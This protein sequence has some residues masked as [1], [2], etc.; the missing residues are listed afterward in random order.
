MKRETFDQLATRCLKQ[1]DPQ[2][3]RKEL[4]TRGFAL[5]LF[6]LPKSG[7][8]T[9]KEMLKHFFKRKGYSV[10]APTEGAEFV[11]WVKR[12]EPEYNFQTAM[13]AMTH[14]LEMAYGPKHSSFHVGI[15]DRANFDGIARME[16]YAGRGTMPR[17]EA[18]TVEDYLLLPQLNGLFDLHV[19][20][21]CDPD[22]AIERELARVITTEHGETMNPQTLMDLRKAHERMWDR[23]GCADD[24]TMLW[25]D[26]TKETPGETAIFILEAVLAAM[27]RR[28]SKK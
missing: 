3:I 16:Y 20:M 18:K 10:T 26:T 1:L 15:F 25:H 14:A 4:Q 12:K 2:S 9:I 24:K 28:L 19:C 5:E 23:L 11:E 13:Y 7:K 6:G 8:T 21:V 22:V 17:E 27:K